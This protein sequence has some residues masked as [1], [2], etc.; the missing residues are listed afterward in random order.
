MVSVAL[1]LLY[2]ALSDNR[3]HSTDFQEMLSPLQLES[4][5]VASPED[6]AMSHIRACMTRSPRLFS[7]NLLLGVCD[8]SISTI[9]K[10]AECLHLTTFDNG[11]DAFTVYDLPFNLLQ[12][13]TVRAGATQ[14]FDTEDEGVASLLMFA[15]VSTYYG[16]EFMCVDVSAADPD[17]VEYRTRIVVALVKDRWYAMPRCRSA[18][19]F[20]EIADAMPRT[21][22]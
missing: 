17:G 11:E 2:V 3:A 8:G 18:H 1:V 13:E 15:G 20:Y 6:A 16:E 19:E 14:A 12:E 10:Y 7:Q 4:E 22:P 5:G 9:N 21:E